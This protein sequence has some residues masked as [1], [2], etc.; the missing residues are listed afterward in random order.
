MVSITI[1]RELDS[2]SYFLANDVAHFHRYCD[3]GFKTKWCGF[4]VYDQKFLDYF[5]FKVNGKWLP[6]PYRVEYNGDKSTFY[7]MDRD[8]ELKETISLE[9]H[10][11]VIQL[12]ANKKMDIEM[13]IGVNIRDISENYHERSY[14][15][16]KTKPLRISSEVGTVSID[17][18]NLFFEEEQYYKKHQG[19]QRCFIP[20][21][22]LTSGESID[23]KISGFLR[24]PVKNR[25]LKYKMEKGIVQSNNNELKE[26]FEWCC[27]DL[28]MAWKSLEKFGG[29]V[30]GYP[31][32]LQ[33]WGRD[34]LWILPA[35]VDSGD[36]EKARAT[37]NMF[38]YKSKEGIIDQM[39]DLKGQ[40]HFKALDTNALWILAMNH[41]IKWSK[42][43]EFLKKNKAMIKEVIDVIK[44]DLEEPSKGFTWMDTIERPEAVEI[45]A[46][47]VKALEEAKSL[48]L[49]TANIKSLKDDFENKYWDKSENYYRDNL[50]NDSI[51][52]N[53]L[54]AVM[55]GIAEKK[56]EVLE[57]IRKEFINRGVRCR[58]PL[59]R[60]YDP[61]GYHK[62]MVWGLTTGWASCCEFAFGNP[63]IGWSYLSF[64]IQDLKHNCIG[65]INEAWNGETLQPN[66]GLFQT[67][68]SAFVIRAIDEFM[69]GFDVNKKIIAKPRIPSSV[70]Y[71]LRKKRYGDK[72]LTITISKENQYKIQIR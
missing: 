12:D 7:Y 69:L 6:L 57:R 59:D 33:F 53:P 43:R 1:A 40:T 52:S 61:A 17:S 15:I 41:Y 26:G 3:G 62:G 63:N 35:V 22:I 48:H 64:L 42:D 67:W 30:A 60:E 70:E 68:S 34:S 54:V 39:I 36:F 49:T 8:L 23:I 66:S 72:W 9:N 13:E 65:A 5:A 71:V 24:S 25:P 46:L 32:F 37:L 44:K 55:L 14:K 58:S 2:Y 18:K 4:W 38:L 21:R 10:S 56:E 20:G 29:F 51:T 31:Y 11:L 19:D 27:K 47:N 45:Y 16:F 50:E 28:K